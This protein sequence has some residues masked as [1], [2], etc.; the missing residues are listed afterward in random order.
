[1]G[2]TPFGVIQPV[3]CTGA[4]A[5]L[6]TGVAMLVYRNGEALSAL[7]KPIDKAV[8]LYVDN[9]KLVDE[10]D[11]ASLEACGQDGMA[12]RLDAEGTS[13]HRG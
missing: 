8:G 10:T 1:M 7:L 9:G 5:D 4:T 11:G 3:E 12:K 6:H 13:V 2:E